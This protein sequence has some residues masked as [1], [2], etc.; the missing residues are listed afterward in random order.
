MKTLPISTIALGA[1]VVV[2][3]VV[4]AYYVVGH[5]VNAPIAAIIAA[6]LLALVL[7]RNGNRT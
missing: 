4:N 2:T 3:I 1:L 5:R 6:P 7:R